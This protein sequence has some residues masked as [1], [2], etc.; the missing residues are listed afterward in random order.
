MNKGYFDPTE[1]LEIDIDRLTK[2]LGSVLGRERRKP[3]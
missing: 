2:S 1:G 3:K